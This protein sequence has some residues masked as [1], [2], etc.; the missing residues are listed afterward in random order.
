MIL[1]TTGLI[2]A[3]ICLIL[4]GVYLSEREKRA[5]RDLSLLYSLLTHLRREIGYRRT[6]L[7]ACF[8]TFFSANPHP[9]CEAF[10][11]GD[12]ARALSHFLLPQALGASLT[13]FFALLGRGEAREEEKRVEEMLG[14]IAEYQKNSAESSPGKR[15]VYITLGICAA[16]VLLLL[17]L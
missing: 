1:R 3:A 14:V 9:S 8:S 10:I 2:A 12:Y 13:S 11:A 16:A 4:A 15:K 6:A 7:P 5:G 17:F